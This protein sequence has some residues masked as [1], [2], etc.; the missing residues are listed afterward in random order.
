MNPTRKAVWDSTGGR[1]WYC[2]L[3]LSADGETIT[4]GGGVYQSWMEVDHVQPKSKGGLEVLSNMVPACSACNTTKGGKTLEEYRHHVALKRD[5]RPRM[6]SDLVEW[7]T[8][9][10]FQFPPIKSVT[11][12]FEE[13]S[14]EAEERAA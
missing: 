1:C 11:F 5:G 4:R 7:L 14:A 9:H 2:G 10:G 12:W 3:R 8:K 6:T 13:E